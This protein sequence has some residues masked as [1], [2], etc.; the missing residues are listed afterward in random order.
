MIRLK[1]TLSI[2]SSSG[3]RIEFD[4]SIRI[5]DLVSLH[6]TL[7][8]LRSGCFGTYSRRRFR[9]VGS[10]LLPSGE[11]ESFDLPLLTK[12]GG[13]WFVSDTLLTLVASK[14]PRGQSVVGIYKPIH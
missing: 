11:W 3:D 6:G 4:T 12:D 14:S 5:F 10:L 8:A 9:V 2:R 13:R 1:S 7:V